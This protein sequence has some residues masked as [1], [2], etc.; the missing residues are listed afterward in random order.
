MTSPD[1]HVYCSPELEA[2]LLGTMIV[3][4]SHGR[5]EFDDLVR[6]PDDTFTV[7][8]HPLIHRAIRA[9]SESGSPV[10]AVTVRDHLRIT[11]CEQASARVAQCMEAAGG[12]I[13]NWEH[14]RD[15]LLRLAHLRR[16]DVVMGR[17][18][19]ELRAGVADSAAWLTATR[20]AMSGVLEPERAKLDGWGEPHGIA[21]FLA[22]RPPIDWFC[23]PLCMGPGFPIVF[24]GYG[25][26]GKSAA[27]QSLVVQSSAGVPIWGMFGVE[28]PLRWL[29]LDYE[30]GTRLTDERY[31]RLIRGYDLAPQDIAGIE[32]RSLPEKYI[33]QGSE[34]EL[35]DLTK[36]FDGLLLDSWLASSPGIDENDSSARWLTDM[37]RRVGEKNELV[38]LILDH[39]RKDA[40][41][42]TGGAGQSMRGSSAKF[43]SAS[44]ILIFAGAGKRGTTNVATVTG[45]KARETGR[46]IEPFELEIS[47]VPIGANPRAGLVV[48]AKSLLRAPESQ[49]E[50]VR[51]MQQKILEALREH[52]PVPSKHAL[53]ELIGGRME[54][55]V[56][57]LDLL[58]ATG[59]V[60]VTKSGR[61]VSIGLV[62]GKAAG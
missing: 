59:K 13:P 21:D 15:E 19:A 1:R 44:T 3:L 6:L 33:T 36:G 5:P 11:G 51:D 18:L 4:G 8:H 16:V 62:N 2:G 14:V 35:V 61:A 45:V 17:Q 48:E 20:A 50:R 29:H 30:Q 40:K 34:R 32:S 25:Y 7:W 23:L 54:S 46:E 42:Q 57:C 9:V 10:S 53:R 39:A 49:S 28:R 26:S 52:G 58:L 47:D 55:V 60:E 41:D 37:L 31:E 12:V 27:A 56:G 24:C 38:P 22:P 43:D